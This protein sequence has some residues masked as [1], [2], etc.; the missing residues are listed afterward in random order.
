MINGYWVSF[1]FG[2]LLLLWKLS[3]ISQNG[4]VI[5]HLVG[6]LDYTPLTTFHRGETWSEPWEMS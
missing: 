3:K 6:R 2:T 1:M 4:T 5:D